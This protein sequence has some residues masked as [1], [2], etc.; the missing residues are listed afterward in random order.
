ML[1]LFAGSLLPIGSEAPDF[2]LSDERGASV[3]LSALRGSNVVLVFYPGD[4]T[5]GCNKQLCAL[6]DNWGDAEA[7]NTRVFGVNP[8][9][10]ESH[11]RFRNKFL[12]PFPLLIDQ[13]R[14]VCALYHAK[15]IW[16]TRTVY[17]I[18]PDGRIRFAQRGTPAVAEIL[19]AAA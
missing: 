11:T 2:T 16:V 9:G 13:G 3:T 18:G 15:G 4:D 8:Q 5:P 17:L 10:A 14:K 7:R 6:R 12:F 1:S 19:A